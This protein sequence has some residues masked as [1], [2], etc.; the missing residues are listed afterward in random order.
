MTGNAAYA[1]MKSVNSKTIPGK[2]ISHCPSINHPNSVQD[3]GKEYFARLFAQSLYLY[4]LH[5]GAK[6]R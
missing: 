3:S 4:R 6:P 1:L 5:I 2:I